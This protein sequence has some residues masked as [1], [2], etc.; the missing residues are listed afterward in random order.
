MNNDRPIYDAQITGDVGAVV[1]ANHGSININNNYAAPGIDKQNHDAFNARKDLLATVKKRWVAGF[2]ES[3]LPPQDTIELIRE[4]R[5][6][7]VKEQFQG[8]K[9]PQQILPTGMSEFEVFDQVGGG[10]SLLI[11]G[12]PGAGKTITLLKLARDLIA[13]AEQ[14]SSLLIPVVFNLS[15]WRSKD[16]KQELA[17]WLIQELNIRYGVAT[18]LGKNW[19]DTRQLILLLDGLDEVKD[20]RREACVQAI[21]EFIKKYGPTKVVVC[22]HTEEYNALPTK[23]EFLGAI[24]LR[25]LTSEQINQYLDKSS[26][27]LATLKV[28]LQNNPELQELA[29][30]PL[31]L[32][33][34]TQVDRG[35][36]KK[37]AELPILSGE[38]RQDLFDAYIEQLFHQETWGKPSDYQS[39]YQNQQTKQWLAWLAQMMIKAGQKE[40]FIEQ[41]QPTWLENQAQKRQYRFKNTL[42]GGSIFGL[43]FGL[44]ALLSSAWTYAP[45]FSW[46][47]INGLIAFVFFGLILGWGTEIKTVET[48]KWSWKKAAKSLIPGVLIVFLA[49]VLL[50]F[51]I[52]FWYGSSSPGY[53]AEES[54]YIRSFGLIGGIIAGLSYVLVNALKGPA[55]QSKTQPNQGIWVSLKSAIIIVLMIGVPIIMLILFRSDM[56]NI[57]LRV[58][59]RWALIFGIGFGGGVPCIRHLT[60][61]LLLHR[62]NDIPWNYASFLNYATER[63]FMQKVGGGYIFI[64]R[65]LLEHF[66]GMN[67]NYRG[68]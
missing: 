18:A 29:K 36:G 46:A 25:P 54:G 20:D 8:P 22:S 58:G 37:M 50:S 3:L 40:F 68:F 7:A 51:A 52:S 24:Y 12:E 45:D 10:Q 6:D 53:F 62:N 42:G 34:M 49:W 60:L 57:G 1:Q 41:M 31:M 67:P 61:R 66:A 9:K 15:S 65:M 21:N 17:D 16:K 30:S 23:L 47:M 56:P 64:H 14:D 48:I 28:L 39:A 44:L 32:R 11:L 35:Q 63:G 4:V 59:L 2:L 26:E 33:I 13:R 19:I 5:P 43:M 55:I 27:Q 38:C